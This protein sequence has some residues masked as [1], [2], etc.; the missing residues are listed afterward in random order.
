MEDTLELQ[1]AV[2][3]YRDVSISLDLGPY[4]SAFENRERA[5]EVYRSLENELRAIVVRANVNSYWLRICELA[6]ADL[7]LSCKNEIEKSPAVQ[8]MTEHFVEIFMNAID[9][10][11]QANHADKTNSTC[12][13]MI[14]RIAADAHNVF[15]QI[16]DNGRGFPPEFLQKINTPSGRQNY[17]L[18]AQHSTDLKKRD[19]HVSGTYNGP[20]L[21]GGRGLGLRMFLADAQNDQLIGNGPH[22]RLIPVYPKSEDYILEFDNVQNHS[23]THRGGMIYLSTPLMERV[24]L[25]QLTENMWASSR[26]AQTPSPGATSIESSRSSLGNLSLEIDDEDLDDDFFDDDTQEFSPPNRK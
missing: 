9:E 6:M 3:E 18:N 22:K 16:F 15:I 12:M 25:A 11:L 14:I 8:I 13:N 10:T 23:S 5:P 20:A 2:N 24:T 4:I 1:Y 21:V 17:M 19:A 26:D 7:S